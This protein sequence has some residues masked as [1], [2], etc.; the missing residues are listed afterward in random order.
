[1]NTSL[2]TELQVW[3]A[4]RGLPRILSAR[5]AGGGQS[6]TGKRPLERGA[7]G[8]AWSAPDDP[9]IHILRSA[10]VSERWRLA[11]AQAGWAVTITLHAH[12]G[13]RA[14]F[15]RMQPHV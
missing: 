5:T 9:F 3:F 8:Q 15:S 14:D 1:M 11:A 13:V 7:K 12:R 4:L 2:W 6:W 10:G